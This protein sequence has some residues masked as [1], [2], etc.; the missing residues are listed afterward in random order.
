MIKV[1]YLP[2]VKNTALNTPI[3]REDISHI[4]TESVDVYTTEG[5]L[6]AKFRKGCLSTDKATQFG[7]AVRKHAMTRSVTRKNASGCTGRRIRTNVFGFIDQWTPSQKRKFK[8]HDIRPSLSIRECSFNETYP[9]EHPHTWP[10]LKEISNMYEELTPEAYRQQKLK[11]EE[12][13]PFAIEGTA[14]TTYTTNI[15]F[16]TYTH[17]DKGD[18]PDGYGNVTV[19]ELEE[20]AGG[21]TCLP[22]FGVGFDV[23]S[24]DFL[25]FDVHEK[26]GNLAIEGG[27]R[28]SVICYLRYNVWKEARCLPA[29][30]LERQREIL[31]HIRGC[32]PT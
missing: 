22:D 6:L 12:C 1:V 32:K 24:G 25:L 30:A 8:A 26:H 16:Q 23:R 4:F 15:N 28:M 20:Y 9:E 5:K 7:N 27:M 18:D 21:E 13:A 2:R 31:Q 3:A 10:L 14:F 19:L 29:D 17:I 11:A